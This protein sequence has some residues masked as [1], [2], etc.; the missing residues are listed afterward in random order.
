M[1]RCEV[2][3]DRRFLQPAQQEDLPP[4][5]ERRLDYGSVRIEHRTGRCHRHSIFRLMQL[6]NI[7]DALNRHRESLPSAMQYVRTS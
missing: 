4:A 1:E 7:D 5:R 6:R 3:H 2:R